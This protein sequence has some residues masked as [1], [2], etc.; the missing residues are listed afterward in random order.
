MTNRTGLFG[1]THE[2]NSTATV[3]TREKFS[4]RITPYPGGALGPR[5]SRMIK[6]LM[7][8]TGPLLSPELHP[9]QVSAGH[10]SD[11]AKCCHITP[12]AH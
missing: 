5:G 6:A 11:A 12:G 9:T 8:L 3:G 2:E 10:T 4:E 7:P 1:H